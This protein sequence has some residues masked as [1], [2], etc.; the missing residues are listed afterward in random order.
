MK[1]LLISFVFISIFFSLYIFFFYA[2]ALEFAIIPKWAVP[3]SVIASFLHK[4]PKFLVAFLY[5]LGLSAFSYTI[6]LFTGII[7][8]RTESW[9]KTAFFTLIIAAT[10]IYA[11]IY[12]LNFYFYPKMIPT[13]NLL[14]GCLISFTIFLSPLR[15]FPKYII[16][17]TIFLIAYF[18][19]LETYG[20]LLLI[21]KNV[22]LIF[23]PAYIILLYLLTYH[24]IINENLKYYLIALIVFVPIKYQQKEKYSTYKVHKKT[25]E[26]TII[27]PSANYYNSSNMKHP[28]L[29]GSSF[30]MILELDS[31]AGFKGA[32]CNPYDYLS[33]FENLSL[34]SERIEKVKE[35]IENKDL[36][37]GKIQKQRISDILERWKTKEE[38]GVITLRVTGDI[39]DRIGILKYTGMGLSKHQGTLITNVVD[40]TLP[41]TDG[42]T[43]FRN[44]PPGK[45]ELL[46]LYKK[47]V[48]NYNVKIPVIESKNDTVNLGRVLI[49]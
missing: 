39:P 28:S 18:V 43:I 45:Y 40:A 5:F 49:K 12:S 30:K 2:S 16:P 7:H 46:L 38:K 21:D 34:N 4:A 48:P 37:I 24:F 1:K 27:I 9:L 11:F 15:R 25:A 8:N 3:F 10:I 22:A 13:N 23:C 17:F 47:K 26:Y 29:P 35:V 32:E 44:I 42:V 31:I 36:Y 6:Y 14:M 19:I 33:L 41:G 20:N